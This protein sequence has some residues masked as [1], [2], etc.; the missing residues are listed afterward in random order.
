CVRE[1]G[2]RNAGK[3]FAFHR[4]S[5]VGLF[6]V[7]SQSTEHTAD[8]EDTNSPEYRGEAG[9]DELYRQQSENEHET[10]GR[11]EAHIFLSAFSPFTLVA[12]R[13]WYR[14]R[15][16]GCKSLAPERC[17]HKGQAIMLHEINSF[18]HANLRLPGQL[19]ISTQL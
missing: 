9:G 4:C 1:R 14:G 6:P 15:L 18:L 12:V 16:C 19:L 3:G 13:V 17:D 2:V 11:N 10:A 5:F 8:V 7:R